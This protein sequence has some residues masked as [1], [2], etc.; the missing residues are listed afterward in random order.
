MTRAKKTI[1]IKKR[2]MAN[3]LLLFPFI[4]RW[5]GGFVNDPS[6]A[7]GA[8]NMGVTISTWKAVGYDKDGDGDIDVSDL[9]LL[10]KDDVINKVFKPHYWDRWKADSIRNQSIANILVDWVW[11]SGV[12]GIKRPQRILG[13]SADGIVGPLTLK[14]LNGYPDQREL[15]DRIKSDRIKFIDEICIS[16]REN[17]RFKRGWLNRLNDIK[18]CNNEESRNLSDLFFSPRLV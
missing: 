16:R 12:H 14:A 18:Y 17:L 15:F 9:K 3:A 13:V 7:G 6:D 2:N 4:F 11:A 1:T 10:T 5:E 8:T